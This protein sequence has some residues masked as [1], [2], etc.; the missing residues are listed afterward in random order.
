MV[1]ITEYPFMKLIEYRWSDYAEKYTRRGQ[2]WGDPAWGAINWVNGIG[3][4]DNPDNGGST[5]PTPANRKLNHMFYFLPRPNQIRKNVQMMWKISH[6]GTQRL[7]R[8]RFRN[9]E[10]LE[11]RVS[12]SFSEDLREELEYYVKQESK[13]WLLDDYM[14]AP[15]PDERPRQAGSGLGRRRGDHRSH[16]E[17]GNPAAR[18]STEG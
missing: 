3:F 5:P 8:A 9:R 11:I 12:G 4:D 14:R 10:T 15:D 1:G 6:S 17:D 2:Y 13:F 16:T 18:E 7:K